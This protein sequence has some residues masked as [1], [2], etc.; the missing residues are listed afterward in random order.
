MRRLH[1]EAWNKGEIALV[2]E[3]VVGGGLAD[4]IK[5]AITTYRAAFPDLQFT[6]EDVIAEGDKVVNR[7]TAR[8]TLRGELAGAPPSGEQVMFAGI[9]IAPPA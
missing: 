9:S 4:H 8:G 6:I 3:L 5:Q 7:W 1:E 2:D